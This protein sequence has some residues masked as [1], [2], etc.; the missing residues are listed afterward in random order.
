MKVYKYELKKTDEQKVALPKG[1]QV[2]SVK[3]QNENIVLY[4]KVPDKEKETRYIDVFIHGTGHRTNDK[5]TMFLDT[6]M[7]FGGSLVF[8]VFLN[9]SQYYR[10]A[11]Y[12]R[13]VK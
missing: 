1:S 5:A 8:H 11:L 12:P 10:D 9:D 13:F 4:V 2:L 3:V 6:I 7:L